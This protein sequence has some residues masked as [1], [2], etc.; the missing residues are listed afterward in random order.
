MVTICGCVSFLNLVSHFITRTEICLRIFEMRLILR[1]HKRGGGGGG[2]A[3][4]LILRTR[5]PSQ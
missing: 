3:L 1:M 5:G 2:E 4:P